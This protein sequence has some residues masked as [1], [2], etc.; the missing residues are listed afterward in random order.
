MAG[1][2]EWLNRLKKAR[3]KRMLTANTIGQG[4]EKALFAF[5]QWLLTSFQCLFGAS[6]SSHPP[7]VN[8]LLS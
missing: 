3:E 7:S 6:D 5:A 2:E 1:V 4:K 8:R